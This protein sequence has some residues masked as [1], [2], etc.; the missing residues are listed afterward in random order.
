MDGSKA[1]WV[2]GRSVEAD[3][4]IAAGARRD[5][6]RDGERQSVVRGGGFIPLPGGHS[7]AGFAG[8]VWPVEGGAHALHAL[9]RERHLGRCFQT[10]GR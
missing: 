8:T 6:W 1:L 7:M 10:S 3:R 4:R 2:T 9:V 5:G